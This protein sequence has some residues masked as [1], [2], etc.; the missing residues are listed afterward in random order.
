MA[1]SSGRDLGIG[2][3]ALLV[4]ALLIGGCVAIFG[5]SDQ[6][7]ED[8]AT[9]NTC[10]EFRAAAADG[11]AGVLT[12]SELRA[13]FQDVED[14]SVVA[15]EAVS[16]AA[17]LLLAAATTGTDDEV[18]AAIDRMGDACDAAGY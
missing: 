3:G 7:N 8:Q 5:P 12:P 15:S 6:D 11:G 4:I 9:E 1:E 17:I 16:S 10:E 18:I 13:R 14:E 2:C